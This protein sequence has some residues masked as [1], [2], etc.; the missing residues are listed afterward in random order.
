MVGQAIITQRDLEYMLVDPTLEPTA[1]PLSLLLEITH[2]FSNDLEIG[3]GGFATVYKATLENGS[4]AVK[5]LL[6]T[7]IHE[8]EFQ[9]EVKCLVKV[10]HKNIV[11]FLGYCSDTQGNM[12]NNNGTLVMADVQQRLLVFEYLPKGS[13]DVYIKNSPREL[14]WIERYRVIKGICK[15]L[16]YLHNQNILHLDLKPGNILLDEHMTP[17]ITDFGQSRCIEEN[18][19]RFMTNNVR[20][21]LGYW[22]PEWHENEG[23]VLQ[24]TRKFD[25]Y[26]LGVIIMELLTGMKGSRSIEDV[27]EIW[28]HKSDISWW[29]QIQVCAEIGIEC[30]NLIPAKRPESMTHII[31]RILSEKSSTHVIPEGGP[32]NLLILHPPAL[33]FPFEANKVIMCPLQLTN[34]T[35]KHITF[36][37]REKS[38]GPSFLRLPLYGVVPP[39]TPC[40]LI[41]PTQAKEEFP[42]KWIT[43]LILHS[44]TF[45]PGDFDSFERYRLGH[46]FSV[47][48]NAVQTIVEF[49][50]LYTLPR[51]ITTLLSMPTTP[52][53]KIICQVRVVLRYSLDTN[54]D[55]QWIIVGEDSGHVTIWDYQTQRKVD[56]FE[57]SSKQDLRSVIFIQ[58][59][60]WTVTGTGN[61]HVHVYNYE[62]MEKITSF[63][64]TRS[65]GFLTTMAVHPT[66][67]YL[68]TAG[69]H[70][71]LWDWDKGWEC[72]QAF[73]V[74]NFIY[75][76]R[77]CHVA[78]NTNHNFATAS[79][80]SDNTVE[81]VVKVW[82]LDCPSSNYALSGHLHKVNCLDFFTCHSNEFLIT[83]SHD[84]TAKIWYLQKKICA[85][86]LTAFVA[87]VTAVL[88]QPSLETLITGTEDGVLYFWSTTNCRIYSCPPTLKII[89]NIDCF[90]GVHHLA[91]VMGR[92][93]IGNYNT[94]A[95][96][97][98]AN[99]NWQEQ[100]TNYNEKQI[101][102][103][104]GQHAGDTKSKQITGSM[105]KLLDV[106]PQELCFPYHPNEPYPCLLHLTNNTDEEVAFRLVD[107]SGKSPWCFT[108]LPLYGIVPQRSTQTLMVTTKEEMKLER[109][110][111]FDLAIQSYFLRDNY[112]VFKDRLESDK[113][114]MEAEQFKN[115]VHEV[116]LEA[117]YP[118][119]EEIRS[120]HISVKYN[121]DSICSLDTHPT[122][123]WILTGHYSGSAHVWNHEMKHPLN[124]FK[125]SDDEVCSMKFIA[126]EC[127]VAVTR[128]NHLHVYDCACVSKIEKIRSVIPPHYVS[129]SP[130]LA[131]HPILPY[132]LLS[133]AV[134]LDWEQGW[135]PKQRFWAGW[136]DVPE[137]AAFNPG[138]A[139]CFATGCKNGKVQVWLLGS[140]YPEYSF[141]GHSGTVNCV[142][143][144]PHGGQHYLVSC[145][146][147][148]TIMIWDLQKREGICTIEVRAP[149]L[150]VLAHPNLPLLITGTS[151]GIIY[152]WS[153]TDFRLKRTINLGGG[154]PIVSLG[155]LMALRRIVIRQKNTITN[156]EITDE[157][158]LV[159]EST[160]TKG[161]EAERNQDRAEDSKT[162]ELVEMQEQQGA[163]AERIQ[164]KAEDSETEEL[165][166]MEE[167]QELQPT[168]VKP[169]AQ[170]R[171]EKKQ[172]R[173]LAKRAEVERRKAEAEQRRREKQ[174][175]RVLAMRA[176]V[177][178]SQAE[179]EHS[180]AEEWAETQEHELLDVG[181]NESARPSHVVESSQRW[182]VH[183]FGS[184]STPVER[185]GGLAL[186]ALL[187]ALIFIGAA[188]GGPERT[189]G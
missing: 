110:R 182:W 17:K 39:N 5:K 141:G 58:R 143:F 137:A 8:K 49:K 32:N 128:D 130:I 121:P 144:I 185:A 122:E 72:V 114:F 125:V 61:G 175:A 103:N 66:R 101:S 162:E 23:E 123:L 78:F 124:S 139:E 172:A 24:V 176:Q 173:V 54:P 94:V 157:E 158:A 105:S 147:D 129:S 151:H 51:H 149:V 165:D 79:A 13:L 68:L 2:G 75:G 4:V 156:M 109:A 81:M 21:T 117:V 71:K 53:I 152:V 168:I 65:E 60:Q 89:I 174:H 166:E 64:V 9:E 135:K 82:S 85:Y 86:T 181:T 131:V 154:G 179:A 56:S 37:L 28:S 20:G 127:I 74:A 155:Y 92:V 93:V 46:C 52:T 186:V 22:A 167:Q 18:Q 98:I 42:R 140:L 3:R 111:D 69:T 55:K 112:T 27:R 76:D 38:G 177:V 6:N 26:S 171:Q 138:D 119:Y 126:R 59:K 163:E 44:A 57:L 70:M 45:T 115:M 159:P 170:R 108:K 102:A 161:A 184:S 19:T 104:M 107:R 43:D 80:S 169:R 87:P 90:G 25:L 134:V 120:E 164:D 16:N 189:H 118:M 50:A 73:N 1:L 35:D 91:C 178:R 67:P 31:D 84:H 83:G 136:S 62:K 133:Q 99:K 29:G 150:S 106:S 187:L 146:E 132:V 30:T 77:V 88:Y 180:D 34:N 33:R 41:V 113:F 142:D 145:S 40:T 96:M 97:E 12:A 15:G 160:S 47:K 95:I 63:R 148:G 116:T 7:H 36:T 48:R 11:R 188:S 183:F 10:K 153:S 100:S 14:E